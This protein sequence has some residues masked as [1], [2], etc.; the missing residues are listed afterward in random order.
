MQDV[1][2]DVVDGFEMMVVGENTTIRYLSK[3]RILV[4]ITYENVTGS[5]A[6]KTELM[7]CTLHNFNL[8][9]AGSETEKISLKKIMKRVE[10]IFF[11]TC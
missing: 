3:E 7:N 1:K 11:A 6:V 8:R 4:T 5:D 10:E 9:D 2:E